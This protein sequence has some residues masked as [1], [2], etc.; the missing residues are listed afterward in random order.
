MNEQK[1]IPNETYVLTE[2][3]DVETREFNEF[4]AILLND[5]KERSVER[6]KTVELMALKFRMEDYINSKDQHSKLVG[7][8]LKE[9][10]NAFEVRQN[11]FA[12]YIGIKPSNL[13]KLIKGERPLN[14]ELALVFGTIF[15]NDPKLWLD[16]QDKN[17]LYELSKA[18]REQKKYSLDD[19]IN[20]VR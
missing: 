1:I 13:S 6:K 15:K 17:K 20:K 18:N 12:H 14:H 4:Q 10:L 19:L 8:F 2:R 3:T 16:I 9:Y 7:D 11:T 5:S